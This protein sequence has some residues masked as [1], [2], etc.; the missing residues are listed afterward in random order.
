[1]KNRFV[2][3]HLPVYIWAVI[4]FIGSSIS[5]AAPDIAGKLS[6]KVCHI[7]EYM[8][9]GFLLARSFGNL[10]RP[11]LKEKNLVWAVMAGSLYGISDE[12]HQIFVPTRSFEALDIISDVLGSLSGALLF[13]LLTRKWKR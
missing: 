11:S 7:A 2:R 3:Y 12:V 6:D 5:L 13:L 4:I 8:V 9:F 1:M 10:I